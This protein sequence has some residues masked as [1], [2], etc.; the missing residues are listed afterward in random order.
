M[1]PENPELGSNNEKNNLAR[2]GKIDLLV[3][4]SIQ[5]C[6][7]NVIQLKLCAISER[8]MK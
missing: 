2:E 1:D 7:K 8:K 3:N 5:A 4:K 6:E